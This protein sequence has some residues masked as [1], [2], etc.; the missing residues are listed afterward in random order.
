MSPLVNAGVPAFPIPTDADVLPS[1]PS[2]TLI[3]HL[4]LPV[5]RCQ[6][7]GAGAQVHRRA[8]PRLPHALLHLGPAAA[9]HARAGAGAPLGHGAPGP[10]LAATQPPAGSDER[11]A[12]GQRPLGQGAQQREHHRR[13]CR[14]T[15]CGGCCSCDGASAAA[16]G[17]GRPRSLCCFRCCCCQ[18]SRA[19]PRAPQASDRI[20]NS[21][22]SRRRHAV[23]ADRCGCVYRPRGSPG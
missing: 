12:G 2:L 3:N 13:G 9:H 20:W 10:G 17:R 4:F 6:V 16:T 18:S 23:A 7:P 8:L 15:G 5:P 22:G 21:G 11:V 19:G 1:P 14:E